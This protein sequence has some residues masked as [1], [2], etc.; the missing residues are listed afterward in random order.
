MPN[1]LFVYGTL[2]APE[3]RHALLG[4]PFRTA[5]A[6]LSG[7][8]CFGVRQAPYPAI[9]PVAGASTRGELIGDLSASDLDILDD[10]ESSMYR[11]HLVTVRDGAGNGVNAFTYVIDESA[12]HRL[13]DE[14]WDYAAFRLHQLDRYLKAL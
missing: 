13:S 14:P 5:P 2:L 1:T 8:A 9:T 4:R 6:E 11:R 12:A 10:Y 7:Y 3:L